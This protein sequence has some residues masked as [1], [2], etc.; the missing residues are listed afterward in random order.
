MAGWMFPAHVGLLDVWCR[1]RLVIILQENSGNKNGMTS[2]DI[3]MVT[4]VPLWR[5]LGLHQPKEI[6]SS[7][8]RSTANHSFSQKARWMTFYMGQEFRQKSALNEVENRWQC[9]TFNPLLRVGVG[10][11]VW[12]DISSWARIYVEAQRLAQDLEAALSAIC[13]LY[14]DQW[15]H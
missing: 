10:E 12:V 9:R 11:L 14:T 1:P 5:A 7:D 3:G 6:N 2:L 13:Q 4:I 8:Y 15:R